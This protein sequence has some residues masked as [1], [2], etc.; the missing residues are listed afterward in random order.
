[1]TIRDTNKTYKQN[2]TNIF[3]NPIFYRVIHSGCPAESD[4]S[5]R[6]RLHIPEFETLTKAEKQSHIENHLDCYNGEVTPFISLTDNL[7]WALHRALC[8]FKSEKDV[9]ILLI[10][11]LMLRPGSYEKLN[12][13]RSKCGLP[14]DSQYSS[15][16]LVWGEI[17]KDSTICR[18]PKP[19]IITSGLFQVFPSLG[20]MMRV[21][22]LRF[23]GLQE[24]EA[25]LNKDFKNKRPVSAELAR[26]L[27]FLDMKPSSSHMKQ[28]FMF[29][30]GKAAGIEVEQSF[31][32]AEA[33]IKGRCQREIDEFE[34]AARELTRLSATRK[35]RMPTKR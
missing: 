32:N 4:G 13:L 20:T 14:E 19:R 21:S 12:V 9:A 6:P 29:I 22:Y 33:A 8:T 5:V 2:P 11:P 24:L 26:A 34:Q 7:L 10:D 3:Q 23:V 31:D 25:Q 30:L 16:I 17:P 27:R 35:R 28:V 18:W 1:M 15:E